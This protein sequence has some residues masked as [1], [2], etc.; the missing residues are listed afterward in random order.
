MNV[1]SLLRFDMNMSLVDGIVSVIVVSYGD[2]RCGWIVENV[3]L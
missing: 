2:L 3:W 1:V